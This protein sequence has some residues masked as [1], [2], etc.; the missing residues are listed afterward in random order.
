MSPVSLSCRATVRQ[1]DFLLSHH[2]EHRGGLGEGQERRKRKQKGEET[3]GRE[4][5]GSLHYIWRGSYQSPPAK[6]P[7]GLGLDLSAGTWERLSDRGTGYVHGDSSPV[8]EQLSLTFR[9]F[10]STRPGWPHG[11]KGCFQLEQSLC[12]EMVMILRAL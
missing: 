6:A 7:W 10:Y 3:V 12:C 1:T 4:G 11:L 2:C 5:W 9:T 8:L